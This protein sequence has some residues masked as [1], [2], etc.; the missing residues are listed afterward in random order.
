LI[1]ISM[2]LVRIFCA[3]HIALTCFEFP[4]ASIPFSASFPM[5]TS[6]VKS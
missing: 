6:F 1:S 4:F 5:S 2:Y 3:A